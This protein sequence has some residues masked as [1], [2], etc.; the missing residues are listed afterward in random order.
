MRVCCVS[1][2]ERTV[3]PCIIFKRHVKVGESRIRE[4]QFGEKA[5]LCKWAM[6]YDFNAMYATIMKDEKFT[7]GPMS[8]R[9]AATKFKVEPVGRVVKKHESFEYV[10]YLIWKKQLPAH[11]RFTGGEQEIYC[12]VQ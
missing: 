5:L 8:L 4:Q 10:A 6:V 12:A 9:R 1:Q 2:T 3:V 7:V 11:S